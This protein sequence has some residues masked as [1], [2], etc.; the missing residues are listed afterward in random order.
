[1][2][3]MEL[4]LSKRNALVSALLNE[5]R[6][7]LEIGYGGD[8]L[9]MPFRSFMQVKPQNV[10]YCGVDNP[11]E[12]TT[13]ERILAKRGEL[14]FKQRDRVE[15]AELEYRLVKPNSITLN[16][17]D[18]TRLTFQSGTF[19]EVHM[20]YVLTDPNITI[21]T[22]LQMLHEAHRV[23]KENGTLFVTGEVVLSSYHTYRRAPGDQ[24][25]EILL[26]NA[27]FT[28]IERGSK[29]SVFDEAIT[30]LVTARSIDSRGAFVLAA[31]K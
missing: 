25:S 3:A 1:M 10:D 15:Q 18:G 16:R 26:K 9:G 21:D 13:E 12:M 22:L 31:R 2:E 29:G 8:P 24:M 7:V 4:A 5:H 30:G 11:P 14:D 19:D 17:M 20:H 27:G 23:L 6:V 28:N